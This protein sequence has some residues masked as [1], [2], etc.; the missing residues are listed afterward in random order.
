ME[1]IL[2]ETFNSVLN[3]NRSATE[4]NVTTALKEVS[5]DRILHEALI[6]A[7]DEVG[8]LFEQGE[9]FVPEMLVAAQA[10]RGGL[11]LLKP[12][13]AEKGIEPLGKIALGT[14]KGD[15]H[16]IGKNLVGMMLEGAGFQII[17]LG[18]DAGP[19]NFIEAIKSGAQL[20]GMSALLTTTM[21]QMKVI[22]DEI[23][24][25]N[26]RDTIKVIIGGAP[27]TQHY[28]DQIGADGFAT[29]ASSAV[30]L[31][32]SLIKNGK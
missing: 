13:L 31:A 12:H 28:A 25:Q 15:L 17:D 27:I 3:G 2:Q 20:I 23:K 32:R 30:A 5:P 11:A 21:P 14:V 4:D 8:R 18:V 19:E 24:K 29:D 1:A 7:M 6:P 26:L 9:Y 22:I 16:D 10:M